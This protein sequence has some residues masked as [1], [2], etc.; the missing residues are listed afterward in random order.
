[1]R[2]PGKQVDIDGFRAVLLRASALL[3]GRLAAAQRPPRP[4]AKPRPR[5]RVQPH[6]VEVLLDANRLHCALRGFVDVA[7]GEA[8]LLDIQRALVRLR[9]GFDVVADVSRLG[10]VAPAAFPLLRRAATA[11]VE[12]G[13]RRLVRVVGAAPGA[14]AIVARLTEGLFEARVATSVMEAARL[15]DGHLSEKGTAAPPSPLAPPTG[16]HRGERRRESAPAPA[17][18]G[19]R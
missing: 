12:G 15:L 6:T 14:A 19:R 18:K 16:R 9:P 8:I 7:E 17:T 11:F 2:G 5:P 10:G 3:E 13:M 4:R 1:M